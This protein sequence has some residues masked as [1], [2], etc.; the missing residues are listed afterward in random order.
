MIQSIADSIHSEYVID[1]ST[2]LVG[3]DAVVDGPG[4]LKVLQHALLQLLGQPV[5]TDE[6]LEVLHA[7]VIQR[8]P[9]VHPLDDGR[10]VTEHHRVHQGWT[11]TTEDTEAKTLVKEWKD[12]TN[13]NKAF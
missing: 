6:V 1:L 5:H 2:H 11:G 4:G 12:S 8:A 10:H 7:R 3:I 13:T 9:G